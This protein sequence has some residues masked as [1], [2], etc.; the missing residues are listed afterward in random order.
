[1]CRRCWQLDCLGKLALGASRQVLNVFGSSTLSA[2]PGT[3]F[4]P[5]TVP[6]GLLA[7][8]TNIGRHAQQE[9]AVVP[10]LTVNLSYA[11]CPD[12]RVYVG[13]TF[14][15]WN[16]V[17]RPSDQI[18]TVV[19]TTQVPIHPNFGPLTGPAQ[20]MVPMRES[21]FWAQGISIG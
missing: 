14:L 7:T 17:L 5:I 2:T 10:E 4:T 21:D 3:A 15:Y 19:N 12:C 6:G 1:F 16:Q 20:P 9:F 11:F 8:S 13:Y 18:D